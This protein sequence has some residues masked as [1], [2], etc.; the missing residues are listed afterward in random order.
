MAYVKHAASFEKLTF[1]R[2]Q[3]REPSKAE[4]LLWRALRNGKL[5]L[6][7]RRQHPIDLFVLD[8]YCHEARLCVE[9]DG[10]LH[11]GREAYDRWRDQRLA[12]VGIRTLRF[13]TE[14][15]EY[16]TVL[17]TDEILRHLLA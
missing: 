5:G 13:P 1:A 11:E 15:V 2:E 3:R 8:F 4:K 14:A 17:V 10:P 6:K 12:E 16:D 9:V 7:F